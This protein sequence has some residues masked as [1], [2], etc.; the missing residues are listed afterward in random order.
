VR[1]RGDS[2]PVRPLDENFEVRQDVSD[3]GL[4]EMWGEQDIFD[5]TK[6]WCLPASAQRVLRQQGVDL[7]ALRAARVLL[8]ELPVARKWQ[9]LMP[10]V[11]HRVSRQPP[12]LGR[13]AERSRAWAL[14]PDGLQRQKQGLC[15]YAPEEQWDES[16]ELHQS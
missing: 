4:W 12:K 13:W 9:A 3:P 5:R 8:Q 1:R 16:L 15:L 7:P 10:R 11:R 14:Q 6:Y 2:V